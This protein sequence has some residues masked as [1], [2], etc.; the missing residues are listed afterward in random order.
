MYT[1]RTTSFGQTR[2]PWLALH[3]SCARS[4]VRLALARFVAKPR[5]ICR[6]C[7]AHQTV[8]T[9]HSVAT[10]QRCTSGTGRVDQT[11]SGLVGAGNSVARLAGGVASAR[12]GGALRVPNTRHHGGVGTQCNAGAA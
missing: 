2:K 7:L 1:R 12:G 9:G 4:D 11:H 6:V 10:F 8:P 5:S 3:Y